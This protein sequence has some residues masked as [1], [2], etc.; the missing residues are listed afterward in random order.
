MNRLPILGL[1][2]AAC[3]IAPQAWATEACPDGGPLTVY[4]VSGFSCQIGDLVFSNFTYT[5]S[6]SNQI[7]AADVTVDTIGPSGSGATLLGP[8]IGLNFD[9]PWDATSGNSSDADITFI[10]TVVGGSPIISDFGLAQTGGVSGTGSSS[11]AENGCGPAPCNPQGGAL[12]VLTFAPSDPTMTQ[13]DT[14]FSPV[15]SVEVSKDI[16]VTGG[17]D[18]YASITVVQDTFSQVSSVPEPLTPAMIGAGLIGLG[19]LRKK[20]RR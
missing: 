5:P 4:L 2:L 1:A 19:V 15:D 10:V 18:G 3:L 8:D 16:T 12:Q 11:V 6:G 20:V 14:T 13:E 17:S 9:A 7:P